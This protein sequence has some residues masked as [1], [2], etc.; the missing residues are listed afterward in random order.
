MD[1]RVRLLR[2]NYDDTSV[3]LVLLDEG[4]DFGALFAEWCKQD[5]AFCDGRLSE[6]EWR[7]I[8]SFMGDRGVTVLPASAVHDLCDYYGVL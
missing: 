8:A 3:P 1:L 6:R 4:Q 7:D 5:D 2:V